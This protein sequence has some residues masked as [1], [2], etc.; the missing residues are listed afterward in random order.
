MVISVGAGVWIGIS[1]QRLC[2]TPPE[3]Q[4][5]RRETETL[6]QQPPLSSAPSQEGST[7]HS[8]ANHESYEARHRQGC[9]T[10]RSVVDW[11]SKLLDWK[12][13]DVLLVFF[14]WV[15]ADKTGNLDRATRGLQRLGVRQARDMKE[16]LRISNDAAVA[17][18]DSA[19][20]AF[21]SV[22]ETRKIFVKTQRPRLAIRNIV[23]NTNEPINFPSSWLASG[24]FDFANVGG[25]T[26]HVSLADSIAF[27]NKGGLPTR[28][29]LGS[30]RNPRLD[31]LERIKAMPIVPVK[32]LQPGEMETGLFSSGNTAIGPRESEELNQPQSGMRFYV[33]GWIQYADDFGLLRRCYF[34]R[35]FDKATGRFTTVGDPDYEYDD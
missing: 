1:S 8:G 12:L 26:A 35:V 33:A 16:S 22:E 24:T 13:T 2:Q 5:E 14:T 19:K 17:A 9:S 32:A 29:P 10:Y 21:D 15:L 7:L 20:A 3:Q 4:D 18:K 31:R 27:W 23:L 6:G 30:Q 11:F 28:H 34:C 25:S